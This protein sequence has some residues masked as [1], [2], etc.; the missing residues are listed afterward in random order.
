MRSH[1]ALEVAQPAG[2]ARW[3]ILVEVVYVVRP[4]LPP[5]LRH[6]VGAGGGEVAGA[7]HAARAVCPDE[8]TELVAANYITGITL[9]VDG[10]AQR[11]RS[12]LRSGSL[13]CTSLYHAH[14]SN[15]C[16]STSFY[17]PFPYFFSPLS[18]LLPFFCKSK[19]DQSVAAFL[20]LSI[21]HSYLNHKVYCY[22]HC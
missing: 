1:P 6:V 3:A 2:P 9:P 19:K 11:I 10:V 12:V 4:Y 14:P 16:I 22:L 15:A 20:S 17:F 8:V 13:E 5:H 21:H 7:E 18:R